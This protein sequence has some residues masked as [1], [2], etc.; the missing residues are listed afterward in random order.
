MKLS[1]KVKKIISLGIA[2]TSLATPMDVSY[3]INNDEPEEIKSIENN[4]ISND[5]FKEE[6]RRVDVEI[7]SAFQN[8]YKLINALEDEL[9]KSIEEIYAIRDEIDRISLDSRGLENVDGIEIFTNLEYL[10]LENNFLSEINLSNFKKLNSIDLENNHIRNIEGMSESLANLNLQDNNIGDIS[11]LEEYKQLKSLNLENNHIENL[12]TLGELKNLRSLNLNKNYSNEPLNLDFLKNIDNLSDLEIEGFKIDFE[13]LKPIAENLEFLNISSTNAK[14]EIFE[15]LKDSKI[16]YLDMSNTEIQTLKGIENLKHLDTAG[17]ENCNLKTIR[18]IENNS[19]IE[20]L[21]LSGNNLV[22]IKSLENC[23]ELKYLLANNNNLTELPKFSE[24]LNVLDLS[25]NQIKSSELKKIEKLENINDMYGK[26]DLRF[27][28]LDNIAPLYE[29]I[30]ELP[31]YSLDVLTGNPLKSS[32]ELRDIINENPK[33]IEKYRNFPNQISANEA[34]PLSE[35]SIQTPILEHDEYLTILEDVEKTA[36]EISNFDS[37]LKK[38]LGA[39]YVAMDKT[40]YAFE[41][42]VL[43][44]PEV[45]QRTSSPIGLIEDGKSICLGNALYLSKVL[46]QLDF[47]SKTILMPG[48]ALVQVD[49]EE[50]GEIH[51]LMLDSTFDGKNKDKDKISFESILT[52]TDFYNE[53][54]DLNG[55]LMN[56][57]SDDILRIEIQENI[58][59]L[60]NDGYIEENQIDMEKLDNYTKEESSVL[61]V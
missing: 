32:K 41:N 3:T 45:S 35:N 21:D 8:N 33:V 23:K 15:I 11:F 20:R 43:N 37:N 10:S 55:P 25:H 29:L 30:Q 22:S 13:S 27:N 12:S 60:I 9:K 47:E 51:R 58:E 59:E 19:K 39:Y 61:D 26:I 54:Y 56:N 34:Q 36:N 28:Q 31:E 52:E 4:E 40:E 44:I 42:E 48:H 57:K 14:N 38:I 16:S 5:Y 7:L 46:N 18:H 49:F 2:V 50:N 17:F 53:Y 24:G 6:I 1:D